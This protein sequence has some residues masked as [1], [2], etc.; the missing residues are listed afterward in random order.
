MFVLPSNAAVIR[1]LGCTSG[2]IG[3]IK[4]EHFHL[5]PF[6]SGSFAGGFSTMGEI[7]L[8][9]TGMLV[10]MAALIGLIVVCFSQSLMVLITEGIL[11]LMAGFAVTSWTWISGRD[12][13]G[14]LI[15]H[16]SVN[17]A[18]FLFGGL[19]ALIGGCLMLW[20]ASQL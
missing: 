14:P 18:M 5:V 7:Y 11:L 19:A 9:R 6:F 20:R 17:W 12:A 2:L 8:V 1:K 13:T 16:S 15:L 3:R 4:Y 10:V